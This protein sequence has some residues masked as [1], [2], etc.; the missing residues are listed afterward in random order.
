MAAHP[1]LSIEFQQHAWTSDGSC[2]DVDVA[3]QY[4]PALS[5]PANAAKL[6]VQRLLTCAAPHYLRERGVPQHPLDLERH[7]HEVVVV[8]RDN[9]APSSWK[10]AD[11]TESVSVAIQ[12]R[13]EVPS[14]SA[15]L[16]LALGGAGVSQIPEC[17]AIGHVRSGRLVRLLPEWEASLNLLAFEPRSRRNSNTQALLRFVGA[18][19]DMGAPGRPC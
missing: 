5:A 11:S 17:W 1:S 7:H 19:I 10:F 6:G 16:A 13:A 8:S 9:L 4:A 18:L 2:P 15:A 12:K 14:L 3:L